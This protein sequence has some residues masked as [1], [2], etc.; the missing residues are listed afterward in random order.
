MR[1]YFKL[2]VNRA[3]RDDYAMLTLQTLKTFF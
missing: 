1:I 3:M 2:C